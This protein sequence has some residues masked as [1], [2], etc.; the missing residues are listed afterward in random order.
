MLVRTNSASLEYQG[1]S[2]PIIPGMTASVDVLTGN[3][4]VLDYLLKPV[5]KARERALRER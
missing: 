3:K 1:K 2:L 5:L 4:T